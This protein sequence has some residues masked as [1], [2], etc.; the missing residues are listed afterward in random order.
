MTFDTG[1]IYEVAVEGGRVA[2]WVIRRGNLI[3]WQDLS[4]E[5]A[6]TIDKVVK[7]TDDELVF[8]SRGRRMYI[9]PLS[10]GTFT[11]YKEQ[12][13]WVGPGTLEEKKKRIWELTRY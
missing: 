3:T 1:E 13:G 10:M 12:L 4:H 5:R 11:R 6:Y 2:R 7:E 8:I 9:R